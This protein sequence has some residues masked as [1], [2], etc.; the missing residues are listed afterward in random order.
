[1][2]TVREEAT[3]L[4]FIQKDVCAVSFP[5]GTRIRTLLDTDSANASVSPDLMNGL[6]P[7]MVELFEATNGAFDALIER[8]GRWSVEQAEDA[9]LHAL[10]KQMGLTDQQ[11]IERLRG[12]VRAQPDEAQ[13]VWARLS[14]YRA[15]KMLVLACQRHWAWAGTDLARA[16]GFRPRR[17]T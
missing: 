10:A 16:C 7:A 4:I 15:I 8:V 2:P 11:L 6:D 1:M 3:R 12:D 17:A 14:A 13:V 5:I 9:K